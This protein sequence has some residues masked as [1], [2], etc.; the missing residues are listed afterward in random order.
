MQSHLLKYNAN[1]TRQV[2]KQIKDNTYSK[3]QTYSS[4]KSYKE[5]EVSPDTEIECAYGVIYPL[6][7]F[8]YLSEN[9]T[10]PCRCINPAHEDRNPSAFVGRSK[11][12]GRLMVKCSGC[13]A[14]YFMR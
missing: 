1:P 9:E 14:L 12:S 3:E 10:V 5:N 13:G 4:T 11:S 2:K 8:E 7:H 6:S